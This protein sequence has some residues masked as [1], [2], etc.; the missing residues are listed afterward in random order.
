MSGF[1]SEAI[2]DWAKRHL[3]RSSHVLS[4]GLTCCR[5]VN[6]ANCH[7]KAAV[8]VGTYP[9]DLPQFRWICRRS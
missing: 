5:A 1:N 6:T 3:A 2:S 8:T 7:E 4:D 9:N